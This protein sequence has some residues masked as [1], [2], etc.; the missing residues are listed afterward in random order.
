MEELKKV[1]K[2]TAEEIE[3]VKMENSIEMREEA[4]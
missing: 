4:R 3:K 2:K 1:K